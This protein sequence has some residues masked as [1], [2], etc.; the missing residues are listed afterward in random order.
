MN[1]RGRIAPLGPR[2]LAAMPAPPDRDAIRS[3]APRCVEAPAAGSSRGEVDR[4]D[5]AVEPYRLDRAARDR[6]RERDEALRVAHADEQLI[7]P[8]HHFDVR[9]RGAREVDAEAGPHPF[10]LEP[11]RPRA[12]E[13]RRRIAVAEERAPQPAQGLDSDRLAPEQ[14]CAQE[15]HREGRR[16]LRELALLALGPAREPSA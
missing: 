6:S 2:D 8:A 9:R 12:R 16:D 11:D 7:A 10:L 14:R 3:A 15:R 1:R 5:T 4:E 13:E